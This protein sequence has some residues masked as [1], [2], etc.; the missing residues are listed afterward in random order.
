MIR[1]RLEEAHTITHYKPLESQF[2]LKY[3][4]QDVAVLAGYRIVNLR[5]KVNMFPNF[6]EVVMRCIHLI[7]A[8]HNTAHPHANGVHERPNV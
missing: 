5:Q 7:V 8:A 3:P 2:I 6:W 1:I 4:V